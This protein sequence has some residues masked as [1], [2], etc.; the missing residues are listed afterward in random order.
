MT[1]AIG[2]G[3]TPIGH[4]RGGRTEATKDGWGANRSHI[5]IDDPR[6]AADCL[7]GLQE[8]S[9]MPAGVAGGVAHRG[10]VPLPSA[11]RRTR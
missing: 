3:F 5:V 8:V 2:L 4:V 7:L 11:R 6:L 9:H 10:A 1:D